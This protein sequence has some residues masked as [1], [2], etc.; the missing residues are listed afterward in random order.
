[1]LLF[2]FGVAAPAT[3]LIGAR[4]GHERWRWFR[5]GLYIRAAVLRHCGR[6]QQALE[7]ERAALAREGIPTPA[8][9]RPSARIRT[10]Y[11]QV[12]GVV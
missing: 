5:P 11:D 2:I 9:R 3:T 7:S 12:S 6:R 4:A 10:W 1:L 8:K